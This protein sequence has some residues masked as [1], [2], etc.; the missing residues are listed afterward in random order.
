[1]RNLK[2]P[3]TSKFYMMISILMILWIIVVNAIFYTKFLLI[4]QLQLP[5]LLHFITELLH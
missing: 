3:Y 2:P 1:M 4:Y 5:R